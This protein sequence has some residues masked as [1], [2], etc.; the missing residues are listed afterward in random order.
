VR[1]WVKWLQNENRRLQRAMI[2]RRMQIAVLMEAIG[3]LNLSKG[4]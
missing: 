1:T 2:G 4:S 3:Q